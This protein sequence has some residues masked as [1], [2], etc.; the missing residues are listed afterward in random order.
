[1]REAR[2]SSIATRAGIQSVNLGV[3]T[4]TRSNWS[5]VQRFLGAGPALPVSFAA[6][7]L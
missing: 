7:D 3:A 2:V 4:W 1:M 6:C 5:W